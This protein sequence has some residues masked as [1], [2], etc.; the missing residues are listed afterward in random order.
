MTETAAP[1]ARTP[2][3]IRRDPLVASAVARMPGAITD[4]KEVAGEI[5][6]FIDRDSIVS[7]CRAFK[8]DGFNY[9][10]DLSG[11]DYSKYPGHTG[12]RFGVS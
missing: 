12:P 9:L 8:D 10:V 7:V 4:A 3:E 2:D 5:T 1:A 11:V 6:L